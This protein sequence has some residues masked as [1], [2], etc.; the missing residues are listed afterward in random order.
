MWAEHKEICCSL[1]A[2]LSVL[3]LFAPSGLWGPFIHHPSAEC[4]D[5]A[6]HQT[7]GDWGHRQGQDVHDHHHRLS[8]LLGPALLGKSTEYEDLNYYISDVLQVTLTNYTS[9]W[10]QAKNSMAHEVRNSRVM[11]MLYLWTT[12]W[13]SQVS[14]HICFVH[15]FVNPL[16][17]LVLHKD[18]RT[19]ALQ[20]LCCVVNAGYPSDHVGGCRH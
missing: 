5:T 2:S 1:F 13:Y 10:K 14:L 11:V 17:F 12:L 20:M 8:H 16:L 7:P 15:A 19:K 9:D 6:V 18:M 3:H 4:Q